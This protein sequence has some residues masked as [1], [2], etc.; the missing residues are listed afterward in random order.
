MTTCKGF[1]ST[2]VC[3]L[4]VACPGWAEMW[5]SH[6]PALDDRQ[7]PEKVALAP[8]Q[9][10]AATVSAALEA[11]EEGARDALEAMR[12][13]NAAGE[14]PV[15][16]GITRRLPRLK[17]KEE[18]V[19]KA[20]EMRA[21][22]ARVVVQG[23]WRLRL[24]L[25][26]VKVPD[27]TRLWVWSETEGPWAFGTELLDSD[28]GIWSPSVGGDSITLHVE[29]P[30]DLLPAVY[31]S[32][33]A[34]LFSQPDPFA[35]Q[36]KADCV[37]DAACIGTATFASINIARAAVAHIQYVKN[38]ATYACSGALINDTDDS[39]FVPLFLTAHHCFSTGA[40]AASLEAFWDFHRSSCGGTVPSLGSRPRSNG[41]ALLATAA[42]TDVTLVRFHS[43]VPNGP[44]GRWYLGWTRSVLTE[45]TVLHR[46]SH[47]IPAGAILPQAYTRSR[48]RSTVLG[49][50]A[51]P[52]PRF[53][54]STPDT[55]ANYG[56]SSGAPAML[57]SGHVVGQ[58]YGWCGPDG[59]SCN[60][61][62]LHVDG[63]LRESWPLL[64]PFLDPQ[65]GSTDPCVPS[66]TTLCVSKSGNDRRF[67]VRV[68]FRSS[69][70]NGQGGAVSTNSI[71][72][73]RG[74]MFWFFNATNPEML[75][76]ILDGCAVNSRFWVYLAATTNVEFTATVRD[77]HTGRLRTYLNP[78]NTAA[79][80][81]QDTSAFATCP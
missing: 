5:P 69:A 55:G 64:A 61:A 11:A 1:V 77:T 54:Y 37:A 34:Q 41:A 10:V 33:L 78:L 66:S 60:Y 47:P 17:V 22:T 58:L 28:G 31:L 2:I 80:P 12:A 8:T 53:G 48:V 13:Y 72:L 62:N 52:R 40:S 25:D 74:G 24:R 23:A 42:A 14:L 68:Q 46:V 7:V 30:G 21:W 18:D 70:T 75:V 44:N 45:G 35:A 57:A 16:N 4:V 9:D 27:G 59:S 15:Q 26:D 81:V 39:G 38:G 56:G 65:I 3:Y 43:P 51:L 29:W 49:C 50:T 63:S 71:G 6:P 79:V 76:K 73:T 32:Q 67:E 36:E 19:K 20:G